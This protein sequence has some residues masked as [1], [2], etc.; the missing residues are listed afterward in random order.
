MDSDT[1]K[2]R[3]SPV[4]IMS[5][6]GYIDLINGPQDQSFC[7]GYSCKRRISTFMAIIQ[8]RQT[9][10]IFFSSTPPR[11]TRFRI[12]NADSSIKCVLAL[13]YDSLQ[14]IDV[15]ANTMYIPPTN[16]DL[17]APGLMLDDRPNGVTLSS[18]S[19]SNYFD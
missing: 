15:Y 10:K 5:N 14:H 6:S 17:S 8:S 3:I 18:P 2:R 16:R 7:N 12:L 4:A 11:Q 13:Q 9:Y 19:G 1:E